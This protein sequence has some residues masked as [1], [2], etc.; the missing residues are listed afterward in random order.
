MP[1]WAPSSSADVFW[2][3]LSSIR[4]YGDVLVGAA[5]DQLW[6]AA[7]DPARI[8]KAQDPS[9]AAFWLPFQDPSAGNHR[10]FWALASEDQCPGTFE[11]CDGLDNDCNGLVDDNC[12]MPSPEVCGDG[13][14][15][16]C[17]GLIDEGCDCASVETCGNGKDDDCDS[18]IDEDCLI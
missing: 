2:L 18:E 8:A 9:Y 17:N 4:D 15:N 7:I 11:I 3:A 13:K 16:N 10:A 6:A 14:D 12:C 5:R 1:T